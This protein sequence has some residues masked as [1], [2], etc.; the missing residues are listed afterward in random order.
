M[1]GQIIEKELK[2]ELMLYDTEKDEV[3]V[4]NPAARLVFKLA[5]QGKSPHE[6]AQEMQRNF[7]VNS[8]QDL[9]ADVIE[10]LE[11]LRSKKLIGID[12]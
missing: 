12:D 7:Q 4:L 11:E 10:C 9:H 5:G 1:P 2:S 6:M 3:H 8:G